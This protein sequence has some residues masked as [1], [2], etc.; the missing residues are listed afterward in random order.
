MKYSV[1]SEAYEK[2]EAT[3]KRLE[4]TDLLVGFLKNTPKDMV[5]KVAYLTQGKIYPD[6]TGVEIG[7]A[8]RLAVKA[9]AILS[10]VS[11]TL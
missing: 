3:T 7:V 8:E 2:I 1:M 10:R 5:D 6:F 9:L 4:M 11:Y